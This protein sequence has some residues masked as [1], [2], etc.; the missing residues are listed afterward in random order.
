MTVTDA[1]GKQV[2]TRS[3]VNPGS[4]IILESSFIEGLP[5]G[6]YL[7]NVV[8]SNKLYISKIIKM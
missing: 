4:T 6:I 8:T 3:I 2:L 7:I 5:Q 1:N